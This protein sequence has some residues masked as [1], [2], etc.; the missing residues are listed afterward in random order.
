MLKRNERIGNLIIE[1][2]FIGDLRQLTCDEMSDRLNS[3][4]SLVRVRPAADIRCLIAI[5]GHLIKAHAMAQG[6]ALA[7]RAGYDRAVLP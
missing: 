4:D 7:A 2:E 3:D 5:I 1:E 6:R